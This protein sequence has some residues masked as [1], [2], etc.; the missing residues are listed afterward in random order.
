MYG[1]DKETTWYDYDLTSAYTTCM[2]YMGDPD[3]RQLS[4][5][6]KEGVESLTQSAILRGYLIVKTEFEFPESVKYPSIA[7]YVDK[8]TTA[9]PRKG[10]AFL[11]G[12]E[13]LTAQSQGCQFEISSGVY[14]PFK[15]D[16]ED[17]EVLGDLIN[18]R[19]H[20]TNPPFFG[21]MQT[22]Q[23]LRRG[24]PKGSLGNN[25][26][27]TIGNSIY[28]NIVSG[29]SDKKVFDIKTGQM[30]RIEASVLTN[31]VIA[32]YTT[33]M[34]RALVGE[35]LHNIS[36]LGG[37]VVSVTTDGFLTDLPNL[38]DGLLRLSDG[39]TLIKL[40]R[41]L[42]KDIMCDNSS[43][44][45]PNNRALEL[46]KT[47]L[48]IISWTTRGQL[49]LDEGIKAT[50][51]FQNA[52]VSHD[53]LVSDFT[54]SMQSGEKCLV[55]IQ[56]TLRG[57]KEIYVKGGHT[58]VKYNDH[59]FRLKFDNRRLINDPSSES[60]GVPL[61]DS[62]PLYDKT[63]C[64]NLR[65]IAKLTDPLYDKCTHTVSKTKYKSVVDTSIRV[66]IRGY[67]SENPQFGLKKSDFKGYSD[68][69]EFITVFAP[70][71]SLTKQSISNLKHRKS[72]KRTVPCVGINKEFVAYVKSRIPHFKEDEFLK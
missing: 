1:I 21:I 19:R 4:F 32:S 23:S 63:Q 20:F 65:Q 57:G 31:P 18:Q 3:Y 42:R 60:L 13:Y 51:G 16:S 50:T 43:S 26:W 61:L 55:Y 25:M 39:N 10:K 6:N 30:R 59:S 71:A 52:G 12:F 54:A 22:V 67:L 64:L 69:I 41:E 34:T 48:G 17:P 70:S 38:E 46:K 47:S 7:C 9:Y 24:Y 11:T 66:F 2:A 37:R 29:M 8:T 53:T 62:S 58:T 36:R 28:G 14:I 33:S 56:Q 5:L 27:K 72:V 35:C 45:N 68:I 40:Y 15:T 49:G 44:E